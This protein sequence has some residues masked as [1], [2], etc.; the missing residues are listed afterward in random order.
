MKQ[1]IIAALAIASSS[2]FAQADTSSIS[3]G[4]AL[5][6]AHGCYSCHGYNG[7]GRTPLADGVS[8]ITSDEELFL[9]YLRLR[10][11]QNPDA[12][13]NSMP[14]YSEYVLPDDDARAIYA[15][16]RQLTDE[17]PAVEDIDVF[18]ELINEAEKN[19]SDPE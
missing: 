5:Y 3:D 2:G 15:Y 17:P 19:S 11:D 12:P 13:S 14:S 9:R 18:V 10:A 6:L 8:G 1:S 4:E 16:V 7:T